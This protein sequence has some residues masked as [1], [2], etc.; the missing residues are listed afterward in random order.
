MPRVAP[1]RKCI[2]EAIATTDGERT[3]PASPASAGIAELARAL[4][5]GRLTSVELVELHLERIARLDRAP[6]GLNSVPVPNGAAREEARRADRER[7]EGKKV[8]PLHGL[9]FVVKDSFAVAGLTLAAGS[10]AFADLVAREDASTVA[11]LREAGAIVLGKTTMP[12][13]AAG[14]MQLGVY[15][16][17]RSPYN[18]DYL[19]AGWLSGSSSGSAVAVAAGL[20]VFGLAEETLSS[21][22]S[23]ASNNGLAAYVPSRGLISLRGNWPLMALRDQVTPYARSVDDLLHVLDAIVPADDRDPA[24]GLDLWRDQ[25]AV[26]LPAP[27][28]VRPPTYLDLRDPD[29]LRGATVGVPRLFV[30]REAAAPAFPLRSS[31][32]LLWE[33]AEADLRALG[34]TVVEVDPPAFA[35]LDGIGEVDALAELGYWPAGFPSLEWVRL[36]ASTW[37]AFLRHNGDPALPDLAAVPDFTRIFPEEFHGLGPEFNPMGR[38]DYA[39][40]AREA[41]AGTVPIAEIEGLDEA[42]R[43]LE[44][45]RRDHL[46]DWMRAE[47]IDLLAFPA[48]T[49]AGPAAA[50]RDPAAAAEAW[51]P[52]VNYALGGTAMRLL[53]IPSAVVPMG[54][55]EGPRMPVGITFAG[56]AYADSKVLA[57][58]YAYERATGYRVEPGRGS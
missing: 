6:G 27:S 12:P 14:G 47:R 28:S 10:P 52:G 41:A 42:L 32:R 11:L 40:I 13:M 33:R 31:V 22:R 53:G 21:G 29:A 57:A 49:G 48:H 23:P 50:D 51:R 34:A 7:S 58:A 17:P 37:D 38:Y 19:P 46:E 24:G 9:P 3:E 25:E 26:E 15:G 4:A 30:G 1:L 44:R 56:P 54:L 8:G 18:P 35:I 55:M 2:V 39:G 36:I 43:G 45:F 20:A 16:R 5:E